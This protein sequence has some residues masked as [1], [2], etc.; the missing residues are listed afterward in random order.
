MHEN[1]KTSRA[2]RPA[3][4]GGRSA[5]AQT[6]TADAHA[7]EES[8]RAILSMNQTKKEERS[9]A[10]FGEKRVR[11]RVERLWV[12]NRVVLKS[13][14][15]TSALPCLTWSDFHEV[16]RAAG[17]KGQ[18]WSSLPQPLTQLDVNIPRFGLSGWLQREKMRR[19]CLGIW[20]KSE[21]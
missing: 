13:K 15:L 3:R 7:L 11:A 18:R 16:S 10:E 19:T 17:P 21:E 9:S 8:D 14:E 2:P 6:H 5:K 1:R 20:Q 12:A 4:E